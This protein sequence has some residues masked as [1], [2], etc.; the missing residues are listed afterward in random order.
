[1]ILLVVLIT[2]HGGFIKS[3]GDDVCE[4]SNMDVIK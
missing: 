1:M 3:H 4:T 2:N